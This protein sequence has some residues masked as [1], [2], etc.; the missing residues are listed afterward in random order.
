[1]KFPYIPLSINI[2]TSMLFY[3]IGRINVFQCFS[4]SRFLII[5]KVLYFYSIYCFRTKG[6]GI[7]LNVSYCKQLAY[8]SFLS[9]Q[10][11]C[12]LKICG[13]LLNVIF[14]VFLSFNICQGFKVNLGTENDQWKYAIEKVRFSLYLRGMAEGP[15]YIGVEA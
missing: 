3:I 13:S 14:E 8:T 2:L 15:D 10:I 6:S 9:F 12:S 7:S 4:S 1:M 11:K 5:T